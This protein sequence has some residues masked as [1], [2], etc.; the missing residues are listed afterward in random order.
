MRPK[1]TIR[2]ALEEPRLLGGVL[3]GPTWFAWRVILIAAMGEPL[4]SDEKIIFKELTGRDAEPLER[5]DEL[6][7]VVGRRG[8][9][10]RAAATLAAYLAGFC[11]Y[12][13]ALSLGE[14]GL[15]L[16]VAQNQRAAAVAFG[17]AVGIFRS[18]PALE[19]LIER[20]TADTLALRNGIDLEVRAASFRGLRGVTAVAVIA[21]EA[22]FW[23][24][25]GSVNPDSE[26]LNAVRPSLA[27][28][29]GPLLVISS[30]HARR[31][32]VWTTYR[33]HYGTSG[34]PRVLVLQAASTTMNSSLP[35]SVV[36]RAIER[37]PAA[38]S[39]E[40]LAQFRVD[41]EPFVSREVAEAA[42]DPGVFERPYMSDVLYHAFVDPSGGSHDSMTVGI[43]HAEKRTLVLDAVREFK[44]P[45]SPE[46]VVTE[47]ADL[48]KRYHLSAVT[49]DRY[50]GEWPREVFTRHG[51]AHRISEHT[52]SEIYQNLLPELNSR[53][54]ALLD[55]QR[56]L[57]QL[58]GLERRTS[59]GGRD[60]IDHGPGSHDDLINSA[61][62]ALLLA[63]PTTARDIDLGNLIS[64]DAGPYEKLTHGLY[65]GWDQ[66][67]W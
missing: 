49:G 10:T 59:R 32:E 65:V 52:R 14:R 20:E 58:C 35:Q 16:F 39:A 61:A 21:D 13:E 30:P 27:T 3:A 57:T 15:V 45:F 53:N 25:E 62:G 34:D 38:A 51:V 23:A 37:D 29:R 33:R 22:A 28:T 11:D 31:G 5:V 18:V 9:K 64:V 40:Y 43:A 50:G 60:M 24:V 63:L 17:Y 42:V 66:P 19:E 67:R 6:W 8:G 4:H 47:I 1:V 48:L 36:D 12:S 46:A 54:V 44:P 26:I 41:L 2:A 7:A 55:N 56:L